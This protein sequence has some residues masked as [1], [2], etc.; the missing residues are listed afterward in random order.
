[1][2]ALFVRLG[3][4]GTDSGGFGRSAVRGH[5]REDRRIHCCE[6]LTTPAPRAVNVLG[7][8]DRGPEQRRKSHHRDD[9]KNAHE[10]LL[11]I[12]KATALLD[13]QA[14]LAAGSGRNHT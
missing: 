2:R 9:E 10:S 4:R 12:S 5:P 3:G 11:R 1:M 13:E 14:T 7:D 6:A 8:G